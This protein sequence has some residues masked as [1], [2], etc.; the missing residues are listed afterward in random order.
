M[1]QIKKLLLNWVRASVE[2][3][4][5]SLVLCIITIIAM[6][7]PDCYI[8][9]AVLPLFSLVGVCLH[10]LLKKIP[11][12]DV[13]FDVV[14]SVALGYGIGR[15]L[16]SEL[17][18]F[19]CMTALGIVLAI[20]GRAIA[21]HPWS[22][23]TAEY[24]Y[25]LFMT[26]DLIFALLAGVVPVLQ[27]F[28]GV[29]TV[30]G[31]II[32]LAGLLTMNDL[33]VASLTE[34]K[35]EK[36]NGST[37]VSKNMKRQNRTMLLV[38]YGFVLA[39]SLLG[40]ALNGLKWLAQK[41]Y[42][43]ILWLVRRFADNDI[44][45]EGGGMNSEPNMSGVVGEIEHTRNPFWEQFEQVF[46]QVVAYI[47]IAAAA[48]FLLVMIYKGLK[49]LFAWLK[50]IRFQGDADETTAEEYTDT[51][52]RLVEL[53]DL[54][55]HWMKQAKD[56][57]AEQLRREPDW[58]TLKTV[59]EKVR[60]LYRRAVYKAESAGFH[61]QAAQTAEQ[62]LSETEKY[63]KTDAEDLRTLAG[64]YDAV[65]Y[66]AREPEAARVEELNRKI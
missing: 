16:G 17:P 60:A 56:W 63:L 19:I 52:E 34:V 38:I 43:G 2:I 58:K 13:F 47:A 42:A 27:P 23:V 49:K 50:T 11:I 20:R 15:I 53:K 37:V 4:M 35:D 51:R 57:F 36:E 10:P 21:S 33:N 61:Y 41:L 46:A 30:L 1:R 40:G 54:P 26:F 24:L 65:R 12:L 29:A 32:V 31:P 48:I 55:S 66:G 44:S 22:E 14:L 39:L 7:A 9:V 28:R 25:T 8:W 59:E 6:P 64:Y 18:E 5:V 3:L 45:T 62:T